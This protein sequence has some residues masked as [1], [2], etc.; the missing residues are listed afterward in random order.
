[1]ERVGSRPS[2]RGRHALLDKSNSSR[3]FWGAK[4]EAQVRKPEVSCVY[5]SA[6]TARGAFTYFRP[7]LC[8]PTD[9]SYL[10]CIKPHPLPH[11]SPLRPLHAICPR[12]GPPRCF[13]SCRGALLPRPSR[14]GHRTPSGRSNPPCSS[15][16][17]ANKPGTESHPKKP[18]QR[19]RSRPNRRWPKF[20]PAPPSNETTHSYNWGEP[21]PADNWG[22]VGP[23]G[24]GETAGW[25]LATDDWAL[26]AYTGSKIEAWIRQVEACRSGDPAPT[27]VATGDDMPSSPVR[28]LDAA[29]DPTPSNFPGRTI[30][31]KLYRWA[32]NFLNRE[33]VSADRKRQA[34][35]FLN[36]TREQQV[37][38]I[39]R[40]LE[41]IRVL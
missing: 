6:P 18:Y 35:S 3:V 2:F 37:E 29:L 24:W 33:N 20:D 26:E 12:S 7:A 31:S 41:E 10:P 16:P 40:L 28:S 8:A 27:P 9:L 11:L 25:G 22:E 38:C 14:T 1:M 15:M 36:Q 21:A 30:K 17:N 19:R 13:R 39:R 23:S 34:L 5:P 32:L 4:V